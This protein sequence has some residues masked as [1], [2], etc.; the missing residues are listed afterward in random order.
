MRQVFH[1]GSILGPLHFLICINDIVLNINSA[2]RLFADD[3]S[4]YLTVDDPTEAVR[5]LT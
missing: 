5:R 4:L 1:N 2:V 3:I